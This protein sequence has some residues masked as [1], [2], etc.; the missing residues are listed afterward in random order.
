MHEY[1][2]RCDGHKVHMLELRSG[3]VPR[4][5]IMEELCRESISPMPQFPTPSHAWQVKSHR[6]VFC[7]SNNSGAQ[8]LPQ[9]LVG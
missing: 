3:D 4:E 1:A 2:C 7:S 6:K 9:L 5:T 8:G